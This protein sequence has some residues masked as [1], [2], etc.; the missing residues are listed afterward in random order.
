MRLYTLLFLF[1][2]TMC[3]KND[4]MPSC[5]TERST[6]DVVCIEIYDPV[7]GCDD[8]TYSNTCFAEASGVLR[9]TQGACAD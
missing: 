2:L 7:C 8:I 9:W 5:T 3:K 1:L 6:N 4:D